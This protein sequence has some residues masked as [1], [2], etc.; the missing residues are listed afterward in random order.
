[1]STPSRSAVSFATVSVRTLNPMMIAF[2]VDANVTSDSLIAPTP[3]W[4]IL[5]TT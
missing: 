5:T 1:M 2:D 4:M 3:A